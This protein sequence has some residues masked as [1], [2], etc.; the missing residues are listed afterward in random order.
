MKTSLRWI[1]FT[2]VLVGMLL[3]PAATAV[4]ATADLAVSKVDSPDPVVAGSNVTY[5]MNVTNAGPD[6]ASSVSF[7]DTTPAG[8]T[9]V[10]VTPGTGWTCLPL[11]VGGTGTQTCSNPSVPVGTSTIIL[12]LNVSAATP[13]GTIITNTASAASP[14]DAFTANNSAS[15]TTTV[16]AGANLLVLKSD[17]PDPVAAGGNITYTLT[18]R[19]DGPQTATSVT[20]SDVIPANTTFVSVTPAAGWSCPPLAVGGTGTQTCTIATLAPLSSAAFTLVV[21]VNSVTPSGT[22]IRNSATVSSS[23][24]DPNSANNTATTTTVVGIAADLCARAGAI[25]GTNA[26]DTLNGTPGD[27]IICGGNG[28]DTINGRGGNDVIFGQNGKDVLNGDE[29]NDSIMGGNGK[30]KVTGGPGI[31]ALRGGNARDVLDA[32]DGAPT[33]SIDGGLGQDTCQTD[34]GDITV[35]CP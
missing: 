9:F 33:D 5:T 2:L 28:R 8:T 18:V 22:V 21:K 35:G 7:S 24:T 31:D 20:L 3:P 32:R 19:N 15:A 34:T 14:D 12:V 30:D 17:S 25:T 13:N 16:S 4:A 23:T 26:S 1:I 29:G 10:S 6:A 11:P 27:D